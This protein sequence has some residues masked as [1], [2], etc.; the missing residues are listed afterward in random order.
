MSTTPAAP[1]ASTTTAQFDEVIDAMR[2][3]QTEGD[4][5][6]LAESLAHLIP[7]GSSGFGDIIDAAT[8]EGVV[9]KLSANTLRLYR[10]TAIHW[11]VDDR[12][13]NVSFSAHREAR[14]NVET[15]KEAAKMLQ[16]L[17]KTVGTSKVTVASVRKAVAIKA[18][19]AQP[20][21]KPA[22]TQSATAVDVLADFIAGAPKFIAAVKA[23]TKSTDLDKLDA[24]LNKALAHVERLRQKAARKAQA[25]KSSAPAKKAAPAAAKP[26]AKKA[27]GDLRGL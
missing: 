5:W 17:V 3:V 10:D 15:T 24:G 18:G 1:A 26:A 16:D 19:K 22:T 7:S 2:S 8:H 14:R 20:A 6:H 13:P 12:V 4:R 25:S 11:P 21:Q 9:G 27:T 23:D